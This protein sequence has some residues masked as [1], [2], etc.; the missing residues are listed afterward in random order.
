MTVFRPAIGILASALLLSGCERGADVE[1]NKVP[2]K[3]VPL[4]P[5]TISRLSY[6]DWRVDTATRSYS[7][8]VYASVGQTI[9]ISVPGVEP[10]EQVELTGFDAS[11]RMRAY[12]RIGGG[13]LASATAESPA[14]LLFALYDEFQA[15]SAV[16][17]TGLT[18]HFVVS[19]TDGSVAVL[20][21]LNATG[22]AVTS[23]NSFHVSTGVLESSGTLV[24]RHGAR[25]GWRRLSDG[26]VL[27]VGGADSS[28][29]RS[30]EIWDPSARTSTD[31][32]TL[33]GSTAGQLSSA[34]DGNDAPTIVPVGSDY[35]IVGAAAGGNSPE[36]LNLATGFSP[37]FPYFDPRTGDA[38]FAERIGAT[39]N[40]RL[41]LWGGIDE[42]GQTTFTGLTYDSNAAGITGNFSLPV[43]EFFFPEIAE[44]SSTIMWG[45]NYAGTVCTVLLVPLV[46]VPVSAEVV[47][48]PVA[49]C[50]A[51]LVVVGS[52]RVLSLGGTRQV[53]LLDVEAKTWSSLSTPDGRAVQLVYPRI[54]AKAVR[55]SDG[56]IIVVGG[57][58][59][60]YPVPQFE[61]IL[62]LPSGALQ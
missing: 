16:L 5:S 41:Y 51:T 32:R 19:G 3:F 22:T 7:D 56:K 15:Y 48:P 29:S 53:Q 42:S 6:I 25:T 39:P 52:N 44:A 47:A 17:G 28:A 40:Y 27:A 24:F 35:W 38:V 45:A 12:G 37:A 34:H 61:L 46:S 20:G 14:Q 2:V 26:R 50:G 36:I 4:E 30:A 57:N 60:S 9:R 33:F 49:P 62:P 31:L 11:N 10:I 8:R 55:L 21:G 23:I 13:D 58:S 18:E 59:S 54:G 1:I 43:S